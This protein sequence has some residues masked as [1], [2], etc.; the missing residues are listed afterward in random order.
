MNGY[1]YLL[2]YIL[3]S[4]PGNPWLQNQGQ[5]NED[6]YNVRRETHRTF[7]TKEKQFVKDNSELE[8]SSNNK[9]VMVFS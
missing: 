3:N 6:D 7:G 2:I 1:G 4:L 9:G 5:I 8:R